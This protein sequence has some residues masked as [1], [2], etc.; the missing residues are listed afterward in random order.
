MKQEHSPSRQLEAAL[1]QLEMQMQLGGKV[2]SL[3]DPVSKIK[4]K[5]LLDDYRN[6]QS[7]HF[8]VNSNVRIDSKFESLE[9]P[10]NT[11]DFSE[12]NFSEQNSSNPNS[13]DSNS[14]VSDSSIINISSVPNCA[15]ICTLQNSLQSDEVFLQY[16]SP[17]SVE[18]TQF[19][20]TMS[21]FQT[22]TFK[23]PILK[24]PQ[25]KNV[26]IHR[27]DTFCVSV[28]GSRLYDNSLTAR[29]FNFISR[30]QQR[31]FFTIEHSGREIYKS[32]YIYKTRSPS[33][34]P[35]ILQANKLKPESSLI[36]SFFKNNLDGENEDF[37]GLVDI[38]DHIGTA[39]VGWTELTLTLSSMDIRLENKSDGFSGW[40]RIVIRGNEN[41]TH[42]KSVTIDE[43][44]GVRK[45]DFLL[46]L[47]SC[48]SRMLV[49]VS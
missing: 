18:I 40:A 6:S 34:C 4:N 46:K 16:N 19:N 15:E 24:P 12:T 45:R 22:P 13:S 47:V 42:R 38:S 29:I 9:L 32:E 44:S 14:S 39:V 11:I 49:R 3:D 25:L 17:T 2:S 35:V 10:K 23:T 21:P 28:F 8:G 41:D 30:A 5:N 27:N 33:F 36:F 7:I 26:V 48:K 1:A 20:Q 37:S 31:V 43:F